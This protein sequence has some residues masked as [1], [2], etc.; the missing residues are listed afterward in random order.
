MKFRKAR[1][2]II[3]A[4]LSGDGSLID[5]RYWLSRPDK[6]RINFNDYLID[7]ASKQRLYTAN[8]V[9]FG[10]IRTKHGKHTTNGVILFYNQNNIVKS[11]SKVTLAIGSYLSEQTEVV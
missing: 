6:L 3:S 10:R 5:I 4:R 1:I 9:K 7:E 11:G 2:K 8:F